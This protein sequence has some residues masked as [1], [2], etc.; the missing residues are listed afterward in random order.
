MRAS[1]KSRR[2]KPST[3]SRAKTLLVAKEMAEDRGYEVLH[4]LVDSLYVRKAG[5]T[6]AD[7]ESLTEEIAA[8]TGLP[9]AIEAIYRYV[10]FM[11]SRQFEDV[12][13]PNRFFPSPKT[14]RSRV[15]GL[16]LRRHDTPPLVARMQR[17]SSRFSPRLMILPA[18][19][20]SSKRHAEIVRH[21]RRAWP[22]AASPSRI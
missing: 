11:P 14:A 7:Y 19:L 3:P 17:E 5:A 18:T 20:R 13:V 12:P 9:L 2:T 1:E 16:E 22:T 8:R 10:V 6:R 15:R 21:T 4:A